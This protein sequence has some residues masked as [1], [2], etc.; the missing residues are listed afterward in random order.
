M[1]KIKSNVTLKELE[2]F[3]FEYDSYCH[4]KEGNACLMYCFLTIAPCDK[5]IE[6]SSGEDTI[7]GYYEI[8]KL[9]DLI[10]AGLVEKVEGQE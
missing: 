10:Q 8:E 3:G 5:T 9:F 6:I 7:N 1:L 4:D 2:K